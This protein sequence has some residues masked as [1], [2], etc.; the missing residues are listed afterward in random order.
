MLKKRV[1][2][3]AVVV[4]ATFVVPI[5]GAEAAPATGG[6][7]VVHVTGQKAS[8]E[9]TVSAPR[10]YTAYETAMRSEA[11]GRELPDRSPL[12][13]LRP[14]GTVHLRGR[15]RLHRGLAERQRR[16]EQPDQLDLERL[17]HDPPL[18]WLQP[19][20]RGRG[21][22]GAR[23]PQPDGL[24]QPDEL[25][26]VRLTAPAARVLSAVCNAVPG[27]RNELV[28]VIG[29]GRE[30]GGGEDEWC[31]V[32]A[33]RDP[34]AFVAFYDRGYPRVA[35]YFYRRILCPYTTAELTAETFARVW[36]SRERFDP[37]E[38]LGDRL[39]P[40]DRGEPVPAVELQGRHDPRRASTVG[41]PDAGPRARGPGAHRVAGGSQVA[42]RPAPRC[43]GAP[44]PSAPGGGGAP[45]RAG[46]SLRRGRGSTRLH[47][48]GRPVRV[49]RGLDVLLA[50]ME[51]D[52]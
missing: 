30:P 10:C 14:R 40:R 41:H 34:E 3:V 28:M 38:G 31:L 32:A 43:V 6:Y 37:C 13:W 22:L 20:G 5:R 42:P 1:M 48:G 15:D 7:C 23:A 35:A 9:L 50:A 12:R 16:L 45:G 24:Q 52:R 33:R 49:S 46:S 25:D 47:R 26:P 4:A 11:C 18:R 44:H 39:D 8:G 29:S 36:A 19:H 21:G 27:S 51:G 17:P 2:L